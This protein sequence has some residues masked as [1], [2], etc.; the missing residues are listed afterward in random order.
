MEIDVGLVIRARIVPACKHMG[1]D[2]TNIDKCA[3]AVFEYLK[4]IFT[5]IYCMSI[6]ELYTNTRNRIH[7]EGAL[8]ETELCHSLT[9]THTQKEPW[10]IKME[11]D[12]SL[13]RYWK[14]GDNKPIYQLGVHGHHN[15]YIVTSFEEHWHAP[16][17]GMPELDWIDNQAG[18]PIW[19]F[20]AKSDTWQKIIQICTPVLKAETYHKSVSSTG[21]R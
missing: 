4:P 13:I 12:E 2:V 10:V 16:L 8:A 17:G 20:L 3:A 14:T 19:Q 15:K 9:C 6:H 1:L 21:R 11:L 7:A 5:D 18:L